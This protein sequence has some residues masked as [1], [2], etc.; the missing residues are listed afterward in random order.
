MDCSKKGG[1][2][3]DHLV[4]PNSGATLPLPV[5][6]IPPR[7]LSSAECPFRR[8]SA[9]KLQYEEE[10]IGTA[11]AGERETDRRQRR[12][13]RKSAEEPAACLRF[14]SSNQ[15]RYCRRTAG[16]VIRTAAEKLCCAIRRCRSGDSKIAI[17][18][19][20]RSKAS[21]LL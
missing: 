16:I 19:L 1:V 6:P 12:N 13:D 15:R 2:A 14:A 7:G 8:R 17:S 5:P 9:C 3:P 20:A 11:K 21:P 4:D 10:P 18:L